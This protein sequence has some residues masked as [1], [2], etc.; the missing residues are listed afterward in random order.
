MRKE[1]CEGQIIRPN[2]LAADKKELSN[3]SMLQLSTSSGINT[4]AG[5]ASFQPLDSALIC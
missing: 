2:L 4:E 1:A 5:S 3:R